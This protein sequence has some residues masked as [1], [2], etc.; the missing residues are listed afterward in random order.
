M[1]TNV[2]DPER[3]SATNLLS[4]ILYNDLAK[5]MN[6][7]GGNNKIGFRSLHLYVA[8]EGKICIV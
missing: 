1:R 7:E 4:H 3:K 5:M 2:V 8:F 6:L